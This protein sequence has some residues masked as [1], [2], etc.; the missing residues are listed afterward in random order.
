[1]DSAKAVPP[2]STRG[3][4]KS[5]GGAVLRSLA[6]PGWGQFYTGHKVRGSLAAVLETAFFAGAIVNY[7]DRNRLRDRLSELESQHGSDWPVDDPERVALNARI[8]NAQQKGGDY[9]AYGLTTLLLSIIDSY[10]SAHLYRFE[11]NFQVSLDRR[12]ELSLRF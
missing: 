1:M 10:V 6:L 4:V 11:R 8:K 5:P 9:L 3:K 2:D 12:I 7:R